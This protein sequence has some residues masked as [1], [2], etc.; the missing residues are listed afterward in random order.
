MNG[1]KKVNTNKLISEL[2]KGHKGC[3]ILRSNSF[4]ELEYQEWEPLGNEL[5]NVD[6]PDK[7]LLNMISPACMFDWKKI[8]ED[9]D[10]LPGA[11]QANYINY[12]RRLW[13]LKRGLIDKSKE[14]NFK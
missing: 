4:F 8:I 10:F 11:M 7:I 13:I 1:N 14:L 9:R 6:I 5:Y 12:M 3:S 2:S